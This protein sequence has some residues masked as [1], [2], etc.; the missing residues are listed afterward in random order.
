MQ[1]ANGTARGDE[2]I[3]SGPYSLVPCTGRLPADFNPEDGAGSIARTIENK[4]AMLKVSW[5]MPDGVAHVVA[6]QHF[7]DDGSV[8]ITT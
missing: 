1:L 3:Y 2:I 7:G 4:N 6:T 8:T 5:E